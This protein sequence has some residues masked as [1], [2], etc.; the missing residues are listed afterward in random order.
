[1]GKTFAAYL[2]PLKSLHNKSFLGSVNTKVGM[3]FSTSDI[4]VDENAFRF[5]DKNSISSFTHNWYFFSSNPS[6]G[7]TSVQFQP[8]NY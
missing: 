5:L 6:S 8:Q 4:L 7:V 2:S 3:D 1:M